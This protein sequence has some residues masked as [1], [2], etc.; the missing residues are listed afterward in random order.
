[1]YSDFLSKK[2]VSLGRLCANRGRHG[3]SRAL[4][5]NHELCT[6][7]SGT[8]VNHESCAAGL[9]HFGEPRGSSSAF[10]ALR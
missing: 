6:Y 3:I 2:N 10:R 7:V 8:S 1:M 9:G 4:R 5:V